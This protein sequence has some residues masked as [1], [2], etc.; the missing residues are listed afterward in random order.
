VP[1]RLLHHADATVIE[2]D[3]YRVRESEREAA[4]RRRKSE[5]TSHRRQE[6]W[7]RRIESSAWGAAESAP[8]LLCGESAGAGNT[9]KNSP[10][11]KTLPVA[12][13]LSIYL[14]FYASSAVPLRSV[15]QF[16]VAASSST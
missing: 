14:Q 8:A 12:F 13:A 5:H 1:D 11:S 15:A 3:S 9:S 4:A 2:G 16:T 6:Y 7:R 10:G